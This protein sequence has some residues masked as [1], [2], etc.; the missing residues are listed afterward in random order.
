MNKTAYLLTRLAIGIS[1]FGHGF[2]RLFKL[3][4]FANGV[5]TEFQKSMLPAGL[6]AAFGYVL[7]FAEFITGVL[8]IIGLFTKQ[9]A[10]AGC[11][12]MFLL[13]FGSSMIENWS[14]FTSQLMHVLFFVIL[15][16][17]AESNSCAID[18]LRTK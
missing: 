15:I 2:V 7:P 4:I 9:A 18:C 12:I 1:M 16:Q 11:V 8:L 10:V 13:L 17:F 5:I 14:V 3:Q 6:V